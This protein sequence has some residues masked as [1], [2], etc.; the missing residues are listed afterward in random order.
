MGEFLKIGN[1]YKVTFISADDICVE[2]WSYRWD[3]T[4]FTLVRRA[5]KT[6]KKRRD[7]LS[8][9]DA[10]SPFEDLFESKETAPKKFQ[11][12]DI[13]RCIDLDYGKRLE[14]NREYEVTHISGDGS[15]EVHGFEGFHF[16]KRR[17]ELVSRRSVNINDFIT[18]TAKRIAN[19]L[20]IPDNILQDPALVFP[21]EVT[22]K[23]AQE[24]ENLAVCVLKSRPVDVSVNLTFSEGPNKNGVTFA[25]ELSSATEA[26]KPV[27]LAAPCP[28][29]L[30][31]TEMPTVFGRSAALWGACNA[32]LD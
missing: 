3:R 26:K 4:R 32:S 17:F 13:V 11:V 29:A 22:W 20:T 12:G 8:M 18:K 23:T 19:D 28:N 27:V 16:I 14:L 9:P 25:K 24:L 7:Q 10:M 5:A 30:T 15:V 2:G 31:M 1:E 21:Y 6:S